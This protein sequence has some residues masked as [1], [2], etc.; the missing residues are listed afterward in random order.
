V[1]NRK[2]DLVDWSRDRIDAARLD[3][4][5]NRADVDEVRLILD[6]GID[7]NIKDVAGDPIIIG[8]AWIGAP[9]IVRLLIER[10]A[11][12]NATGNDGKNALQRLL[13][14]DGYSHDGHDKVIILLR[15]VEIY[16]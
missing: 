15:E 7:P 1:T 6:E 9:E 16:E 13:N 4:A 14:N 8:A 2:I 12:I 3:D 5:V 11:D 10:G